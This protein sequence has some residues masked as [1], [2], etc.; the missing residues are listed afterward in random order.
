ML[1]PSATPLER[2]LATLGQHYPDDD[3]ALLRSAVAEIEADSPGSDGVRAALETA[4]ETAQI[5]ATLRLDPLAITAAVLARHALRDRARMELFRE[6]Y[7]V[8]VAALLEGVA[9]LID[10]RWDRLEEEA[11]ETLRKMFLAMARDV[12]VVIIV[13]A[14]RVQLM[15]SLRDGVDEPARER[16][17]LAKETLAVFAPLANRL[18]IWQLKWELEDWSLCVLEP[19]IYADLSRSVEAQKDELESHVARL[20]ESLREKLSTEGIEAAISGRAKH[21]YSI[22]KKMQK[23]D[24]GFEGIFDVTA[25]RVITD[26]I[27][28]CYAALGVVHASWVPVPNEFDDY[29]AKSKDNGYQ[30]LHTAVIGPGGHPFEVQIRTHEMHR[31]AEYGVAAHWAYKENKSAQNKQNEKF[32]VLRQIMSWEREVADPHSF[33][34]SLKTDIFADQVYVFTPQGDI[35][36]L[37]VG[38]TPLDF[39]YRIHTSVGNRCRGARVS[40][41][42]QP[43]DYQLKT[44]DRVEILTQKQEQPSRDWMN[45]S[46]GFLKTSSGRQK[47]RTWF[48]QQERETAVREGKELVEREFARLGLRHTTVAD[49]AES[50]DHKS[51]EDLF[52]AVGYGDRHPQGV[53]IAALQLEREKAPPS[54]PPLP[55]LLPPAARQRRSASGLSLDGV[56]DILGK[57]ARCC[58]PVPGDA[59]TGFVTRGRGIVIHR[60][61]CSHIANSR[62]PERLVTIDWGPLAG[63]KH[64]VDI[65]IRAHERP[66]LLG[67]ISSLVA[68]TGANVASARADRQKDGVALLRMA[69]DCTSADQIVR[70]LQ[71]I[72]QLPEVVEVRRFSGR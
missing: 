2:L 58:N 19:A 5:V 50:L 57:R 45:P 7:G 55:P 26:K 6:R 36:D 4:L 62:E 33:V 1:D 46:F 38:A 23:K 51:L 14:M 42:I 54:E 32:M 68:S 20:I 34:E 61:D 49:V 18:G 35:V 30:S 8:E 52:A 15:R 3:A 37:P 53:G 59:V 72:D 13:L 64:A 17:T 11:A 10:I 71:R 16:E 43:L 56:D 22:Y 40:G 44:G 60:K 9:R 25:V 28:D 69:L 24:V 48:R 27:G 21:I 65:E 12:R 41:H 70:I 39:A 67:E 66:G 31:F 63:E 29:I 47:V